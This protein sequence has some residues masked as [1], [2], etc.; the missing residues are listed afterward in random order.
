MFG[1][2]LPERLEQV[3]AILHQRQVFVAAQLRAA[4]VEPL[5]CRNQK[6]LRR[7]NRAAIIC[8]QFETGTARG[9]LAIAAWV[10]EIAEIELALAVR[11]RQLD[12]D[13]PGRVVEAQLVVT[14][15]AS[16]LADDA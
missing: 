5:P 13:L 1:S 7:A 2:V 12:A 9:G 4:G 6:R 11:A 8:R 16:F 3:E 15:G 10:S 14:L